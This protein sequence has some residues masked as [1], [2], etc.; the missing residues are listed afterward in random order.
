MAITLLIGYT[1]VCV[2]GSVGSAVCIWGE[3]GIWFLDGEVCN[4]KHDDKWIRKRR[5]D[6]K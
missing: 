2:V 4:G 1:L 5:K 3:G 6:R